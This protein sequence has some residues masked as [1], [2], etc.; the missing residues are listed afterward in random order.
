M[1]VLVTGGSGFIGSHVVDALHSDGREAVVF[2]HHGRG[3]FLG[4]IRDATAVSEAMAHVDGFIHLAGV[5]GTQEN[6]ANPR[7]AVETNVI[8][9]L[10]VLEAA[11]QHKVPG[12]CIGIGNHFMQNT[13]SITKSM[14]ERMVRMY[15]K[16]RGTRI[17]VVRAM[18]AY[19]PRQVPAKPYG[20][21]SV[22]K[23]M[24]SFICRALRGDPIEMYGDG[25]QVSDMV[26]VTDVAEALIRGMQAAVD[27]NVF[28]DAIE[29]GP[30]TRN[31]VRKIAE[32]VRDVT[33]SKS[34]L[35]CL[36]PR[37]GE[38]MGMPVYADTETLKLI[39]M[40]ADDFGRCLHG[41]AVSKGWAS[42]QYGA[43]GLRSLARQAM[44]LRFCR[45]HV[46]LS[47]LQV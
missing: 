16:E 44:T 38:Q 23:I 45:F 24:P 34:K 2:D 30:K 26:Y 36:P 41:C 11:A 13:Y 14:I 7:P 25:S 22:R 29:V 9:G 3:S 32:M 39:G 5:L 37:Q 18:N 20:P 15:N 10:N 1:K 19:G 42:G 47:L 6:I 4:D 12:V 8:G 40:D 21:S 28:D 46:R 27:H 17:N 35:V 43:E 33:H 31:T